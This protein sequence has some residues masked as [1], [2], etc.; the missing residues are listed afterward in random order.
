M[1]RHTMFIVGI[2]VAFAAAVIA[3]IPKTKGTSIDLPP[4]EA[5][6]LPDQKVILI[7]PKQSMFEKLLAENASGER[8]STA[9]QLSVFV[10][11]NSTQSVAA[12]L[13]KWDVVLANGQIVTYLRSQNSSLQTVSDGQSSHLTEA[14]IPNGI[15]QISLINSPNSSGK[16][17]KIGGGTDITNQLSGSVK[18]TA[19][20]DGVLFVDGTFIGPNTKNYFEQLTG[21]IE[22][23]RDLNAEIAHMT[24]R[25]ADPEAIKNH[26]ETLTKPQSGTGQ[27]P[28]DKDSRYSFW[29]SLRKKNY[30][31]LL[32]MMKKSKGDKSLIEHVRAE[33]N[34]PRVNLRKL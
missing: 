1:N 32:L 22:A 16:Q 18:I 34:K 28:P 7:G 2:V 24:D 21:E 27:Q 10:V 23:S 14:L 25:N 12:C 6:G 3:I 26:L 31:N 29:Y 15:L 17:I 19:T 30:A 33:L 20:I 4:I 5:M 9:N 8:N 13:V 11:N